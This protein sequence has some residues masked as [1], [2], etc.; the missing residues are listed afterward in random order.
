MCFGEGGCGG[1]R[2]EASSIVW[3]SSVSL[4][5]RWWSGPRW[6]L[7]AGVTRSGAE[8]FIHA[9]LCFSQDEAVHRTT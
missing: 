6:S 2:A 4:T 3:L 1:L 7:A 8:L 5:V 9:P